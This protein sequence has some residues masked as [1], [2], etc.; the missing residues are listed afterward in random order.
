MNAYAVLFFALV[1]VVKSDAKKYKCSANS[2]DWC[3][4]VNQAKACN[5][6]CA[7]NYS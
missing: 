6:S 4:N 2:A 3:K 7:F 5:V 1:L